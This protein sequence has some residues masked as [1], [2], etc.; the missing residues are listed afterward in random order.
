MG[1]RF[2]ESLVDVMHKVEKGA[3]TKKTFTGI[4]TGFEDLDQ[5][6]NGLEGG[7]LW[8]IVGAPGIGKQSLVNSMLVTMLHKPAF[9][10]IHM[11]LN[12]TQA[13]VVSRDILGAYAHITKQ[14][15]QRGR[16]ADR[17]WPR[18]AQAADIYKDA[19]V[20]FEDGYSSLSV[21]KF[22]GDLEQAGSHP[23]I[24][25]DSFRALT[26]G[27][28]AKVNSFNRMNELWE[29]TKLLKTFLKNRKASAIV[30]HDLG[31][32]L[33]MRPNKRPLPLD[34]RFYGE[35]L[36][37]YSD[38]VIGLHRED[39]YWRDT[40]D[41]GIAELILM[42]NTKGNTDTI[43]IAW[44]EEYGFFANVLKSAA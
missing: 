4:G 9:S 26:M 33:D 2:Q 21:M 31:P 24:I 42:K 8:S 43:R 37:V 41:Q 16:L 20:T 5:L 18:L 15:L 14:N 6:T 44:L 29:C 1:K 40:E 39:F 3:A 17:D 28:Q 27:K 35:P 30:L 12:K 22:A 19:P 7:D 13:D 32:S 23:L 10:S 25:I 34:L 11:Y 38:V 36:N